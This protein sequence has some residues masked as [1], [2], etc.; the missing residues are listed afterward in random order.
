MRLATSEKD[1]ASVIHM[2][3][4]CMMA[5]SNSLYVSFASWVIGVLETR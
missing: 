3:R 2:V 5:R 4:L 1:G